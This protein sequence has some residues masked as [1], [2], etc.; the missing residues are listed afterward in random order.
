MLDQ[1]LGHPAA[2]GALERGASLNEALEEAQAAGYTVKAHLDRAKDSVQRA[3]SNVSDVQDN[4]RA[5][6]RGARQALGHALGAFD[7]AFGA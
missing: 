3:T 2:V 6:I 7:R 5:E 1:C 4:G